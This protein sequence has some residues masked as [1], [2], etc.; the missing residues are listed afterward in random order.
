[1][2]SPHLRLMSYEI[3]NEIMQ[4]DI[5]PPEESFSEEELFPAA[6]LGSTPLLDIT[7]PHPSPKARSSLSLKYSER[8][9]K[10]EE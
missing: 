1:M 2:A 10:S 7:L 3:F 8:S 5:T 4:R 6:H 9:E